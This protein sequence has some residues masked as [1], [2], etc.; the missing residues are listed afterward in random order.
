MSGGASATPYGYNIISSGTYDVLQ[1][2][3][4]TLSV[5]TDF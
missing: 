5:A 1:G 3:L 2:R 4:V